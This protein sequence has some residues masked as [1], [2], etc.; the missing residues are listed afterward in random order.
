M[1]PD[2]DH[3]IFDMTWDQAINVPNGR[4]FD[5]KSEECLNI[6]FQKDRHYF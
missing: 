4:D 1:I 3:F 2:N 6:M 5:K